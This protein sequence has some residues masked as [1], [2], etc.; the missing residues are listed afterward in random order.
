[1]RVLFTRRERQ[2]VAV[3]TPITER[4]PHRTGPQLSRIRLPPR[5]SDGEAL[6]R[7]RMEDS[8]FGEPMV[9]E[10]PHTIPGER[11]LLATAVECPPPARAAL[12]LAQ[13]W[14]TR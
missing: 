8:G 1:M 14:S 5:V 3:G 10:H 2:R 13:I 12:A 7:P 4:P 6:P 9:G 11:T